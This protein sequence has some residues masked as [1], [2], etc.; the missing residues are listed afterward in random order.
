VVAL[1]VSLLDALRAMVQLDADDDL[2]E[3]S[4][5]PLPPL[6]AIDL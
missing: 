4:G 3:A 2:P 5:A 6:Q 1:K